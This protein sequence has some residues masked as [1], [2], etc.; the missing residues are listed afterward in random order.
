MRPTTIQKADAIRYVLV[1]VKSVT[2]L[3]LVD[4]GAIRDPN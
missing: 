2:I 1:K 3:T 4:I